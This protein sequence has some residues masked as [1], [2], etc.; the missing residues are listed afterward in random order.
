[1]IQ[2]QLSS[3]F[4]AVF[5]WIA[6]IS[7]TFGFC[8]SWS[9][10]FVGML[11]CKLDLPV[12][13]DVGLTLLSAVLAITFTFIALGAELLR[14][15]YNTHQR[16]VDAKRQA[17]PL[18]TEGVHWQ[19]ADSSMPLLGED[20]TND[21]ISGDGVDGEGHPE[22]L[23]VDW[24][25]RQPGVL[26]AVDPLGTSIPPIG[27]PELPHQALTFSLLMDASSTEP[28][29]GSQPDL[30]IGPSQLDL[31]SMAGHGSAPTQ[32]AF[33][34]TYHGILDGMSWKSVAMGGVWSLSLTCM[35]YG[36][37][38]AMRIPEGWLTFNPVLVV[39]SALISWVVCIAGYIYMVNIEPHLSQQVLFSTIAASGI[40]AMHFTGNFPL[41]PCT[42]ST[43][44]PLS[45]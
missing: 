31:K 2:A 28:R 4:L 32:N 21:D 40:A 5:A 39:I 12:V 44:L 20:L 18:A 11:S 8:A 33:M 3:G 15:R 7:L 36:G 37:L 43:W 24:L 41:L 30:R 13:L 23:P 45:C 9:L 19:E 16:Q 22:V 29:S 14:K 25:P 6:V 26:P 1:M 34:A 38:L 10:H 27:S 42:T 35:H 17:S